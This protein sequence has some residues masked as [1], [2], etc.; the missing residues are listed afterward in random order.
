MSVLAANLRQLY[1]RRVLWVGYLLFGF[2]ALA[3]VADRLDFGAAGEGEFVGLIALAFLVGM[4]AAVLQMEIMSKPFAYCLPGHR[5]AARKFIYAVGV[6]TDLASA[7]LFLFYPELS[8]FG[9]L[10]AWCSAFF[11]GLVFYLAGA[12]LALRYKGA[13]FEQVYGLKPLLR[14]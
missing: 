2:M 12:A 1:Q 9:R 14:T 5:L 11:A 8:F 6:V 3:S 4:C 13:M 7:V 10:A